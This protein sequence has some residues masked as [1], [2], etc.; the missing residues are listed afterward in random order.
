MKWLLVAEIFIY[1]VFF[2]LKIGNF[3]EQNRI[4]YHD[5]ISITLVE[6]M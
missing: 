5:I 3:G 6:K 1:G 4:K 2:L